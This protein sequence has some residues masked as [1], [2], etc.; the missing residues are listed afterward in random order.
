MKFG[1][2]PYGEIAGDGID[3]LLGQAAL[4]ERYGFDSVWIRERHRG[5]GRSAAVAPLAAGVAARTTAIRIGLMPIVGLV[6]PVYLA[7]DIAV[8]DCLSGGRIVFAPER[9]LAEEAGSY[10][11][12]AGVMD[13]RF[14]ESL[15]VIRKSWSPVPF[16]HDGRHFRVPGRLPGN[17]EAAG[18]DKLSVTPKPAQPAVPTWLPLRS[19][20]DADLARRL[21]LPVLGTA[22]HQRDEL[23]ALFE[24]AAGDVP[25]P[26]TALVRDVHVAESDD[27]A[28][29]AALPGL[30]GLYAAYREEGL[31]S[32]S[33]D[34]AELARDRAVVGS[35]DRCIE[36]IER[37]RD[38]L[39]VGY[40]ICRLCLPGLGHEQVS[41]TTRFFGQAVVSEFRMYGFPQALRMRSPLS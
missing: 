38:E 25:V 27:E 36:E 2:G 18:L 32:G 39:G 14:G 9:A 37:Y 11:C 8:V 3:D 13:D 28:W 23:R 5:G 6:N 4:A 12:A 7:E 40:L 20:A 26:V 17:T 31:L 22:A 1:L 30:T 24:A 41:S 29:R 16:Q 34:V 35:P 15:E 21:G 19:A 33:A 10:R